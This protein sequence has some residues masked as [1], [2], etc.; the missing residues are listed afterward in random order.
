MLCICSSYTSARTPV[1]RLAHKRTLHWG[2][3]AA[4]RPRASARLCHRPAPRTW[5]RLSDGDGHNSDTAEGERKPGGG[6]RR[7]WERRGRTGRGGAGRGLDARPPLRR[8]GPPLR[9]PGP[10][11]PG[12]TACAR[13][14]SAQ[15]RRSAAGEEEAARRGAARR[16]GRRPRPAAAHG[17]AGRRAAEARG[18][19]PL[20]LPRRQLRRT[21]D[22]AL[23]GPSRGGGGSGCVWGAAAA[24][25]ALVAC[26][27]LVAWPRGGA[28]K[29]SRLGGPRSSCSSSSPAAVRTGRDATPPPPAP[30]RPPRVGRTKRPFCPR[31]GPGARPG[32]LPRPLLS[33]PAVPPLRSQF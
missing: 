5:L 15:P 14:V 33:P 30:G 27:G 32:A 24:G 31:P 17:S 21:R 6:C 3:A 19:G 2:V 12:A 4:R 16:G 20:A 11:L 10:R 28:Q 9:P 7:R 1:P 23:P 13:A 22:G 8:L 18:R 29:A 25:R 26:R